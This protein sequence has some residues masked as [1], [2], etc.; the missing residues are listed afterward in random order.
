M[1]PRIILTLM[2]LV[3]MWSL[4]CLMI[5]SDIS[6]ITRASSS[7]RRAISLSHARPRAM[8]ARDDGIEDQMM[9][10]W[11]MWITWTKDCIMIINDIVH[12]KLNIS[13]QTMGTLTT[14]TGRALLHSPAA[15][16]KLPGQPAVQRNR[17]SMYH[18][19]RLPNLQTNLSTIQQSI[20]AIVKSWK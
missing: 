4:H 20:F 11:D 2:W 15:S 14:Q 7:L 5:S 17:G 3:D 6:I 16:K 1:K 12:T 8:G 18:I 9:S 10:T 13:M 19:W